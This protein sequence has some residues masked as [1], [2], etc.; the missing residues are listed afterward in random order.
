[1]SKRVS[2][3]ETT[4]DLVT[5]KQIDIAWGHADFG[6]KHSKR[7][8]ISNALLKFTCGYETGHTIYAI[9]EELGLLSQ[10]WKPQ[11]TPRG[12][13]FLFAAFSNGLSV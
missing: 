9:C 10:E 5:D 1:M 13:R 4:E 12:Q 3:R 2:Y 7:E 6:G 8:V 11:L